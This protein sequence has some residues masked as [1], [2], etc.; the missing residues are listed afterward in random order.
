MTTPEDRR[1]AV[2][3]LAKDPR[4]L[5]PAMLV[6]AGALGAGSYMGFTIEPEETTVLR[7]ENATLVE[8]TANLEAKVVT[9]SE[10]IEL[11]EGVVESCQRVAAACRE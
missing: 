6:M 5:I 4:A 7:V 10:R 2:S 11:L 3:A 9:L 1:A 8:R